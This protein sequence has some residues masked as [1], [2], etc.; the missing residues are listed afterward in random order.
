MSYRNDTLSGCFC[1][2]SFGG[3]CCPFPAC[4]CG[5]VYRK[6]DLS[7]YSPPCCLNRPPDDWLSLIVLVLVIILII[8]ALILLCC[9][10]KRASRRQEASETLETGEDYD[11]LDSEVPDEA[12]VIAQEHAVRTGGSIAQEQAFRTDGNIPVES[13]NI[14]FLPS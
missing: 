4:Q 14:T 9:C 7:L 3:N 6:N 5:D 11:E 10:W 8:C 1:D 12:S 13:Y 2:G